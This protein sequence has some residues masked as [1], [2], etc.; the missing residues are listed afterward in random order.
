[1]SKDASDMSRA[2]LEYFY[3]EHTRDP[4]VCSVCKERPPRGR[5]DLGLLGACRECSR[6]VFR[7]FRSNHLG[8]ATS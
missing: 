6:R 7:E 1:M 3:I 4:D 2:E 5:Y 8:K